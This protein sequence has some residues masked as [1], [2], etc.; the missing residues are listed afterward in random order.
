MSQT[1]YYLKLDAA[2]QAWACVSV[3][4]TVN[5]IIEGVREKPLKVTLWLILDLHDFLKLSLG[6]KLIYNIIIIIIIIN[7]YIGIIIQYM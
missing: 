1:S 4:L 6:L 5:V 2:N 7:F 3:S